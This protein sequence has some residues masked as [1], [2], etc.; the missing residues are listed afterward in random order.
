GQER[1]TVDDVRAVVGDASEMALDRIIRAAFSGDSSGAVREFDR[2]VGAGQ[3]AQSV[4]LALQRHVLRLLRFVGASEAGRSADQAMRM[5]RPPLFGQ[6]R[7]IF[8]RQANTWSSERLAKLQDAI[9]GAVRDG[10]TDARL[11]TA[12][13]ERLLLLI[14]QSAG[15]R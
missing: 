15:R 8:I 11:E 14:G 13:A 1:I 10:R 9:S 12:A 3:A 7:D 5:L 6:D 4:L 2:A